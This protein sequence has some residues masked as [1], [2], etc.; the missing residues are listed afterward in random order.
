MKPAVNY[1]PVR[2]AAVFAVSLAPLAATPLLAQGYPTSAPPAAA[3]KPAALPPFQEALLPNGVRL[4]LVEN[5]KNPVVAFRLA[6]PAGGNYDVPAKA[7]TASLVATLLTKGAGSRTADEMSAAIESAGGSLSAFTDDDFLSVSGSVLS[8]AAPLAFEM[9]GDAVARPAFSEKELELARTQT[10]SG[11]Q[12]ELTNP[13]SLASRFLA[14]GLYGK[15]P[16]G[17]STT[18]ATVRAI[19]RADLLA[20]QSSRL[21]PQ[22]ALLVVAGDITMASLRSLAAKG[23]GAWSGAPGVTPT[24]PAPPTRSATEIVLVHRP[25]SV[26]S[27][28]LVGNLAMTATDPMRFSALVA[29]RVLGGSSD[30]R[31]FVMLRE[32]KS[33]TYGS[34]SS[35]SRPRGIGRFEANAEVRTEVTDSALVEMLSQLRQITTDA[36]PAGE[37]EPA[38]NALVGVFPLTIETPQQLA[39][40]V[41]SVKLYGLPPDYLQ[42]YR[43]KVGAV[44]SA[45]ALLG[46]KRAIQ[47]QKALIVV[48]GD[49]TKIYEKLRAI[50]PVKIVSVEGDPMMPS[51]FTPRAMGLALDFTKLTARRDSFVVMVQG[52]A[53]GSSVYA[54]E[55]RSGGWTVRE[56]TGIMGGMIAQTTVL[57][58]D[59][60]LAPATLAQT[61]TMQG[62]AMKTDVTFAEGRAKG[63]AT[64][65]TQTG[66]QTKPIDVAVPAGTID[67]DAL[68]SVLPLFR[69]AADAKFTLNVF[70]SGKGTVEPFTLTVVGSEAV[71]VPAGKFETWKVEQKGGEAPAT[72]FISKDAA[73]R[74]VK[75][76]PVGQPIELLLAK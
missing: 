11:L 72:L 48:V 8:N 62:Q 25:G 56:T 74:V 40:R 43:N 1:T 52:N 33:W 53:A 13:A 5:H 70:S 69:W 19:S 60:S 35:L 67:S 27:N 55:T 23:F 45:Q 38:K 75:I 22:G 12:L 24:W 32:K 30:S 65:P 41:A 64:T 39:E 6:I 7:G 28:L 71:T 10:L 61:M 57:N 36:I 18:P 50:A 63:S 66:P 9:L 51:D 58:T 15:H 47:P 49:G 31:L 76:A 44:T 73:H 26:Q 3:V 17:R 29:N 14:S 46:A 16:Y 2:Y 54:L 68:Q 37:L 4:V 20:F 34:Y 59:A 42:T 21:R